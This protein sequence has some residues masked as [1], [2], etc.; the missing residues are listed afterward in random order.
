MHESPLRRHEA[1]A[2]LE[3]SILRLLFNLRRNPQNP[4]NV[5]MRLGMI[6]D[7]VSTDTRFVVAALEALMSLSP[8]MVEE[9][10]SVQHD[11][12]FE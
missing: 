8:P 10:S 7:A 5:H 4:N 12:T 11:R 3:D 9:G 1:S 2:V 6:A